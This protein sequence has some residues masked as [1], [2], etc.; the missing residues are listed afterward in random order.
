MTQKTPLIIGLCGSTIA[1]R[2]EARSQ[3][4]AL[5]GGSMNLTIGT[6]V[7]AAW[8]RGDALFDVLDELQ[9]NHAPVICI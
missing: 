7:R 5:M 6:G 2:E 1:A 4:D 8:R 3:L 9:P